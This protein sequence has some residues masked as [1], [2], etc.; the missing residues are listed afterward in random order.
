MLIRYDDV[1]KRD[2]VAVT[3]L[4]SWGCSNQVPQ[5]GRLRTT[6]IYGLKALETGDSSHGVRATLSLRALRGKS[7]P[8]P[9][10]SFW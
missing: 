4:V 1:Y 10:P 2:R 9:S 5:T 8:G 7:V 3:L 6:E